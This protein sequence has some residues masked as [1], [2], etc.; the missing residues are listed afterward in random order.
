MLS[1][2]KTQFKFNTPIVNQVPKS[3]KQVYLHKPTS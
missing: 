3:T 2:K 1:N